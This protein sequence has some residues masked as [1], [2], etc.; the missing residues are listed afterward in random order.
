MSKISQVLF[1]WKPLY[2]SQSLLENSSNLC[3]IVGCCFTFHYW[4][5][6]HYLVLNSLI[7]LTIFQGADIGWT[8]GA[9]GKKRYSWR[10]KMPTTDTAQNDDP[11]KP[12]I[13]WD[14]LSI[15]NLYEKALEIYHLITPP[16][17]M[18]FP[19]RFVRHRWGTFAPKHLGRRS[20]Q[21]FLR[22]FNF[23]DWSEAPGRQGP[24]ANNLI[25][26]SSHRH[27]LAAA[28]RRRLW[29]NLPLHPGT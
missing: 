19:P 23:P 16:R 11:F 17:S 4:E 25:V 18:Q 21:M 1:T 24:R 22:C 12:D 8:L 20:N 3:P 10:L 9:D 27:R 26:S 28:Q 5:D 13:P 29:S 15:F 2:W 6:H 14:L 7:I